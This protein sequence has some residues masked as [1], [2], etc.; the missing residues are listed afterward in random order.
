MFDCLEWK[1]EREK[2][3]LEFGGRMESLG[4]LMAAATGKWE[5]VLDFATKL[6]NNK[7]EEREKQTERRRGN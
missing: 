7:V 5:A 3:T 1:E 6:M 4:A 2:L